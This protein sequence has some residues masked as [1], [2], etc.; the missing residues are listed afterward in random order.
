[1]MFDADGALA[2]Q[3]RRKLYDMAVAEKMLVQG[4]HFPF[5]GAGHIEKTGDGYRLHPAVWRPT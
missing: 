5:P 3:T 4:Y 1:M 2:E